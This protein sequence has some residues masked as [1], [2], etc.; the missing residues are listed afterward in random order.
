MKNEKKNISL[1]YIITSLMVTVFAVV[2]GLLY[3]Y[4]FDLNDDVLMKD[5]LSGVYTGNPEGHNIQM[6]YPISFII[7]LFYKISSTVDWYGLFLIV[8]QYLSVTVLIYF[9]VSL[10]RGSESTIEEEALKEAR[11][12]VVYYFRFMITPALMLIVVAGLFLGHLVI[13]QYTFTVALMCSAAAVLFAKGWDKTASCIVI[14]AFLIRS[15][16]TLLMLPFVLL[17][18]F[19]RYFSLRDNKEELKRTLI[20]AGAIL[21]GLLVSKGLNFAGYSSAEWKEF[22]SFFDN[23]TQVYDFYQIP[24]YA[25]NKEFYD[26]IGLDESEYQLLVNY[27]F[28]IDDKIDA[29]LMGKFADYGKELKAKESLFS[30][31]RRVFPNYLYRLR[32]FNLPIGYEYPRTDS[33]WNLMTWI[34]YIYAFLLWL[35]GIR[36]NH[37]W[38]KGIWGAFWRVAILFCGRTLIWMYILVRGR[39]PIRITHSLYL[40]EIFVLISLLYL[41]KKSY[42]ESALVI[43]KKI[44]FWMVGI[45]LMESVILTP[46]M[47]RIIKTECGGRTEYN[48]A[49]EELD[50]YCRSNADSFYFVDV[51]TS[52]AYEDTGYTYSEKMFENVDNSL[53][54]QILMGGWA[55]K[56]P[57]ESK[58]L[59]N[60]FGNS[61]MEEDIL[62]DKACIVADKDTDMGWLTD[63][64]SYKNT[65]ITIEKVDLVADEFVIYKASR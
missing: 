12:R 42:K 2:V 52:V 7:S 41:A 63:Y 16:M 37:G 17:V 46:V 29:E 4:F 34:L 57:I 36:S 39:D 11:D 48:R 22:N 18:L 5:I 60:A 40:I 56:S 6:L 54:N 3:D 28:G 58:K 53:S 64:Y 1:N 65:D 27:N 25:E 59:V 33:P 15:E 32:R 30:S 45:I 47:S 10:L 31:I 62:S 9:G 23:R 43:E 14:I 35:F 51:Y 49:Y 8:C 20:V 50:D 44:S 38:R 19:Y 21:I 13:V 61:S 24:D 26:S 55:C